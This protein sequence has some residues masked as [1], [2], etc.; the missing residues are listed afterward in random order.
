MRDVRLHRDG[1]EVL[2]LD[3]ELATPGITMVMGPNGAGKS[4]LLQLAHGLIAP[5]QGAVRWGGEP[6][7][8]TKRRRGFVFQK[9]PVLR[10]S[11]ADNLRFPLQVAGLTDESKLRE[12]L[13]LARLEDLAD[14]PAAALS[15]G[16]QGRMALARAMMLDPEAVL[17]DEPAAALDPSATKALEAM[18][19]EVSQR[20]V[21]VL[22]TTHDLGQARRLAADVLFLDQGHLIEQGEATDFFE[23]PKSARASG[24]L[25]GEL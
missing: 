16:E 9:T 5:D 8:A 18:V 12:A 2:A 15:G 3:L 20:G 21:K 22:M 19:R 10:R 11:V 14:A 1:R 13:A 4:L 17:L 24:Y 6:V 7:S 23:T 25:R